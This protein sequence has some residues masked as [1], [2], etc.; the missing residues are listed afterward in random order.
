[1]TISDLDIAK[2]ADTIDSWKW[3]KI[4]D[5][6]SG[7]IAIAVAV[8]LAESGG[9]P[10]AISPTGDYGLWQINKAAHEN[11]FN[12]YRWNVP[13]DNVKMA[14]AVYNAKGN[15]TPWT[16]YTSGKYK[17]YLP[18]GEAASKKLMGIGGWRNPDIPGTVS[19]LNPL[20][21]ISNALSDFYGLFEKLFDV[22]LWKRIGLGLLGAFLLIAGLAYLMRRN[23]ESVAK[24][25]AKVA[26]LAA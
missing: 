13:A 19:S 17:R 18:R 6:T 12:E 3:D 5:P 21:D 1:M 9:N 14:A 16:T 4:N 8:C 22:N 7:Q 15:W 20:S 2:L 11:L 10:N 24:T 25:A 26:P 23:I